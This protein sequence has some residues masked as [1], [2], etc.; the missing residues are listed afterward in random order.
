M[1]DSRLTHSLRIKKV[2]ALLALGF[3]WAHKTGEW[4]HKVVKP[5]RIK[6]HGRLEQSLF[7]YG[8]DELTDHLVQTV[9]DKADSIRLLLIFLGPPDWIRGKNGRMTLFID[10]ELA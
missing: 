4:K 5:L 3:C 8:L 1:E 10:S 7:R 9:K 2:M 6:T